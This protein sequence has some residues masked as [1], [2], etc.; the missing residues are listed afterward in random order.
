MGLLRVIVIGLLALLCVPVAS[1]GIERE[2]AA[3]GKPLSLSDGRGIAVVKSREGAILG[4]VQRGRLRVTNGNVY[5]CESRKRITRSTVLCVG[6]NLDFSATGR[7][8]RIVARGSGINASGKLKGIVTLQG[9][10]GTYSLEA[11]GSDPRPWPRAA[12]T[13]RLG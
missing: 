10:S 11:G 7:H 13:F 8:W 5:G 6:R 12:R 1:A 9:T 3:G 4:S 2:L